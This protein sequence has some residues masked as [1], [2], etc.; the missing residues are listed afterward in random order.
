M[1]AYFLT[2]SRHYEMTGDHCSGTQG[3]AAYGT[4]SKML[5]ELGLDKV[6]D[7]F[8][9]LQIWGTPQQILDKAAHRRSIIGEFELNGCFSFTGMPYAYV[10]DSMKLY[11]G[12][13]IPEFHSWSEPKLRAAG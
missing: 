8:V 5:K 4:A 12:K 1:A 9:D 13:Y 10:E 6:A 7:A 2:A 11:G 3:Y